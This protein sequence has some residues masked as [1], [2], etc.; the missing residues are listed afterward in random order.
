MIGLL[1]FRTGDQS[2]ITWVLG[3][4]CQIAKKDLSLTQVAWNAMPT[5]RKGF[6]VHKFCIL[7][8]WLRQSRSI[9]Q[10]IIRDMRIF[11]EKQWRG[12]DMFKRK[13]QRMKLINLSQSKLTH[14]LSSAFHSAIFFQD[15]LNHISLT[16]VIK[17]NV[18]IYIDIN[19]EEKM[20][21][22]LLYLEC[23]RLWYS[24]K[25]FESIYNDYAISFHL[26]STRNN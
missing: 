25:Y 6:P 3:Y 22:T 20:L 14:N 17:A 19:R 16:S 10:T 26:W 5:I 11:K 8:E 12:T 7:H 24:Y 18:Y 4:N 15:I 9:E 1:I 23:M 2:D 21:M 13:M